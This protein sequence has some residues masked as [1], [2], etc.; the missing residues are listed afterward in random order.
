MIILLTVF[1]LFV[2]MPRHLERGNLASTSYLSNLV[3]ES[4]F[5]QFLTNDTKCYNSTENNIGTQLAATQVPQGYSFMLCTGTYP[6]SLPAE[7]VFQDTMFFAGNFTKLNYKVIRLYY[8]R[9][10]G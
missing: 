9:P 3:V 8:W 6:E 2:I 1:F 7:D 4:E 5:K 10:S